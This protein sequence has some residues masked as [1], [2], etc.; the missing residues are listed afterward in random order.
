MTAKSRYVCPDHTRDELV[1]IVLGNDGL[2]NPL[3]QHLPDRVPSVLDHSR[4]GD[5]RGSDGAPPTIATGHRRPT[6]GRRYPLPSCLG[7]PPPVGGR[8][9]TRG[10]P[11]PGRSDV[12][13]ESIQVLTVS[14]ERRDLCCFLSRTPTE[15]PVGDTPDT[16]SRSGCVPDRHRGLGTRRGRRDRLERSGRTPRWCHR[17]GE[18]LSFIES[19]GAASRKI[20]FATKSSRPPMNVER[21]PRSR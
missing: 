7:P 21:Y 19:R 6:Q 12:E 10:I 4:S 15:G 2:L 11:T 13:F 9:D 18:S 14:A 16:R 17:R 20:P 1:R 8:R 3:V 5:T